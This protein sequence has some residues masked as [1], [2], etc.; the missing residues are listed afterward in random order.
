MDLALQTKMAQTLDAMTRSPGHEPSENEQ[1]VADLTA[2][3]TADMNISFSKQP[4]SEHTAAVRRN[5]RYEVHDR[6][7]MSCGKNERVEDDETKVTISVRSGLSTWNDLLSNEMLRRDQRKAME[8]MVEIATNWVFYKPFQ[9]ENDQFTLQSA[10]RHW[11]VP[12]IDTDARGFCLQTLGGV[13]SGASDLIVALDV[14]FPPY[15]LTNGVFQNSNITLEYTRPREI[16]TQ[17]AQTLFD[18]EDE[19]S[20]QVRRRVALLVDPSDQPEDQ[21]E[22]KTSTEDEDETKTDEA[23][24]IPET[25]T[26]DEEKPQETQP[27]D[28]L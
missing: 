21:H 11:S 17:A 28:D 27:S 3:T 15:R 8:A 14:P 22:S 18:E 2:M 1:S 13:R 20:G 6:A 24:S 4:G 16:N 25:T 12:S 7:D 19:L 5:E 9:K 10:I 26:T 23:G